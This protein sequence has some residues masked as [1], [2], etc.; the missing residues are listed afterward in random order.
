MTWNK[1]HQS[2]DMAIADFGYRDGAF[3]Y[4]LERIVPGE[5]NDKAPEEWNLVDPI[6]KGMLDKEISRL[7]LSSL[8]LGDGRL[9]IAGFDGNTILTNKSGQKWKAI[10]GKFSSDSFSR[11]PDI[12]WTGEEFLLIT[13]GGSAVWRSEQGENWNKLD[14]NLDGGKL[15]ALASNGDTR[16]GVGTPPTSCSKSTTVLVSIDGVNW[17]NV[18]GRIDEAIK[19]AHFNQR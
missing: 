14:Y 16:I 3:F 13:D 1:I 4:I 19:K 6:T 10:I 12:I 17:E 8:A 9:V 15:Y 5:Q 11:R 2:K 7:R 18:S